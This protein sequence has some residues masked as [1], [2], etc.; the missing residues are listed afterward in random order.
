MLARRRVRLMSAPDLL[1]F[2]TSNAKRAL[3]M[4]TCRRR[5]DV[6][7]TSADGV[8]RSRASGHVGQSA[9]SGRARKAFRQSPAGDD[10]SAVSPSAAVSRVAADLQAGKEEGPDSPTRMLRSP[11]RRAA[12]PPPDSGAPVSSQPNYNLLLATL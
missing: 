4:G 7:P 8:G 12:W 5:I 11:L 3:L 1:C 6:G 9:Y 10:L 2:A